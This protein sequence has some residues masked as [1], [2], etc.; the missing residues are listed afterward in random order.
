MTPVAI[1]LVEDDEIL[2][3]LLKTSLEK[4]FCTVTTASDAGQAGHLLEKKRFDLVLTDLQLGD[5]SGLDVIR[6]TKAL[7]PKSLV[8]MMSGCRDAGQMQAAYRTGADEYLQ[9]PFSMHFLLTRLQKNGLRLRQ[10]VQC[11]PPAK[12]QNPVGGCQKSLHHGKVVLYT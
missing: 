2:L 5:T 8:F 11:G 10:T 7:L 4:F 9:K 1:L 12:P 6:K 3:T